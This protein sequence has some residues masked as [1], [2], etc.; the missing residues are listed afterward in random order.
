MGVAQ[1]K[2]VPRRTPLGRILAHWRD[3]AGKPGGT[4]RR[5]I[6]SI[7]ISGGCYRSWKA[8]EK[9]CKWHFELQYPSAVNV[10]FAEG[11]QMGGQMEGSHLG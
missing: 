2:E 6:L 7:V 5:K 3:V 9:A 1:R 8:V 4:L 10:V 11:G